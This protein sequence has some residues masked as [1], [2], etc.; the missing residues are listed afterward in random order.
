MTFLPKTGFGWVV[1][2]FDEDWYFDSTGRLLNRRDPDAYDPCWCRQGKNFR[3]CHM[4]R[5]Q[6]PCV[7]LAEFLKGWEEAADIEMC[8]APAAPDG[9]SATVIRAHTVQR[10]GGGLR[11][12]ARDGEV[13]GLEPHPYFFRKNEMRVVPQLIGTRKASTF[14][15]F[16]DLHDRQLFEPIEHHSFGATPEQLL[17]LNFRVIARRLFSKTIAARHAPRMFAYDRGLSPHM[18]REFFAVQ[19]R[20]KLRVEKQLENVRSLKAQYDHQILTGELSDVQA[21]VLYFTGRPDFL[22]A[23]LVAIH[24]DFLGNQLQEPPPPAH[25]CAYTLALDHEWAFVLSWCGAN[26]AAEAL[27][28]SLAQRSDLEKT[29]AVLR[30]SLEHIDNIF[31]APKW[32]DG[33]SAT[34]Q[35]A[36]CDLLTRRMHPHYT[37]DNDV[38]LASP[39]VPVGGRFVRSVAVGSWAAAA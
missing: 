13:Y 14:R 6:E 8:L 31:F 38:L 11:S 25:L 27:A 5:H 19:Y 34:Q 17:V 30:Y 20:D 16:C 22:C 21:F 10:M 4:R 28:R 26:P 12:I 3:F 2:V 24:S 23:E 39:I 9:C 37:W 33:L 35:G 32:W 7:T 15:G 1:E 29:D 36:V 18:Q